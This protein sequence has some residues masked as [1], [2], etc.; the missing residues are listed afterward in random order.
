MLE[1]DL[2]RIFII[3]FK[4]I[5]VGKNQK[6]FSENYDCENLVNSV[7]KILSEILRVFTQISKVLVQ[8]FLAE[9]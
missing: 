4:K 8:K 5:E 2:L 6:L 3:L 9:R 7:A 1:F